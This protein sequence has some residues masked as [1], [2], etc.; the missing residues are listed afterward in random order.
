MPNTFTTLEVPTADGAGA[1]FLTSGLGRPK[2]II[3]AGSVL[4]LRRRGLE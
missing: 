3:F 2:T 4:G 1:P